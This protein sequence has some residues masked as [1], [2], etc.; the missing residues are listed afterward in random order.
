M[1]IETVWRS[2]HTCL[3]LLPL[4][5]T[6]ECNEASAWSGNPLILA[7]GTILSGGNTFAV[8]K[9]NTP[10]SSLAHILRR[11]TAIILHIPGRFV[12][13]CAPMA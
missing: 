12:K 6:Y 7:F 3:T 10:Q 1:Q 13:R 5:R 11:V 4:L 9:N 8:M 2:R